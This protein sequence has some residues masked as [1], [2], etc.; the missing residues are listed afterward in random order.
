MK[1][2]F[3][4]PETAFPLALSLVLLAL[5]GVVS[6]MALPEAEAF[7]GGGWL[8]VALATL[9]SVMA[10]YRSRR[11]L[12]LASAVLAPTAFYFGPAIAAGMAGLLRLVQLLARPP[13]ER[14]RARARPRVGSSTLLTSLLTLMLSGLAAASL[15]LLGAPLAAL[16]GWSTGIVLWGALAGL[17]Q[18]G[19]VLGIAWVAQWTGMRE[20]PPEIRAPWPLFEIAG[21]MVGAVLVALFASAGTGLGIASLAILAAV[22]FELARNEMLM[23]R[24]GRQIET[25]SEMSGVGL[26]MGGTEPELAQVAEQL[27]GECG[28]LVPAQWMHLELAGKVDDDVRGWWVGPQ[29]PI[30]PTAEG[31]A[32]TLP[33]TPPSIPG[34]H[35]RVEWQ[36]LDRDLISAEQTIARL[37]LWTDPRQVEWEQLELLDTLLPQ[38]ATSLAAVLLDQKAHRDALTGAATRSVLEDR[39]VGAYERCCREGRSMAVVMCDI[40]HFKSINDTH[41]HA[42]GDLALQEVAAS[43]ELHSRDGDLCCRYGGEEF[44]VLMEGAKGDE[45]LVA[46]ERL[47]EGL[48]SVRIHA[49]G[50]AVIEVTASLG[51]ASFPETYVESGPDLVPLADAALYEAKRRGRNRSLLALG[52]GR[53]KNTRGRSL[54][55]AL[56]A[57]EIEAPRLFV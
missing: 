32:P 44:T 1:R 57:E 49:G 15:W 42:V 53:F 31:G 46:A 51:V 22:T 48:E 10:M 56:K 12:A 39:L 28:K 29:G 34:V 13:G 11:G 17:V 4:T 41:G 55:G 19:V 27:L 54:K 20:T 16:P 2:I 50:G 6:T 14:R 25:L 18:A 24:R 23:A 33:A 47:R 52:Q 45:A 38:L 9:G 35:R 3:Q 8:V 36:V 21:W 7:R 5:V 30:E 43:L 26:R 37:S 40:D